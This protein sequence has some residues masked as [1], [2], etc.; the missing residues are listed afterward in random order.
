MF[1]NTHQCAFHYLFFINIMHNLFDAWVN[2]MFGVSNFPHGSPFDSIKNRN[3]CDYGLDQLRKLSRRFFWCVYFQFGVNT[4]QKVLFYNFID[5]TW[6]W[7]FRHANVN[8][9]FGPKSFW[10]SGTIETRVRWNIFVI[11][12]LFFRLSIIIA[13]EIKVPRL[14]Y[15]LII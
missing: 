12:F 3:F 10:P 9:V 4:L 7:D 15:W 1:Y 13:L 11:K 14:Y 5:L 8:G 6:F 2:D